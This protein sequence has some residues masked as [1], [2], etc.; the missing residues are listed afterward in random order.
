MGG[1]N[2]TVIVG[3]STVLVAVRLNL[4]FWDVSPYDT[5]ESAIKMAVIIYHEFHNLH[6]SPCDIKGD[7]KG[8]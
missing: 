7:N 5:E 4:V 3:R 8:G 6:S 1:E 2:Y